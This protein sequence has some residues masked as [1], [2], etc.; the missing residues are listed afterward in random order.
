MARKTLDQRNPWAVA[1]AHAVYGWLAKQHMDGAE[2]ALQLDIPF[3]TWYHAVAA[4]TITRP[5]YYARI[6]CRTGLAAADPRTIPPRKSGGTEIVRA[7]S[8]TQW[9]SWLTENQ[10]L[11]QADVPQSF[12][13]SSQITK[14][15]PNTFSGAQISELIAALSA[16]LQDT[17]S[18][19]AQ[20]DQ[21][22]QRHG[23]ELGKLYSLV[24][25]YKIEDD[26][27]RAMA[28][29]AFRRFVK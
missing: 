5:E 17:L 18:D 1:F 8:E 3:N 16:M 26:Q 21:L 28:I 23:R 10:Q 14:A 9:Q 12:A 22:I 29:K 25:I 4:N 15:L 20:I 27:D 2:L 24:S 19:E 11:Y 13:S 7:W 6:F